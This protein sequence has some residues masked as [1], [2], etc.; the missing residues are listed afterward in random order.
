M[1]EAESPFVEKFPRVLSFRVTTE[2]Q[3]GH[4]RGLGSKRTDDVKSVSPWHRDVQHQHIQHVARDEFKSLETIGG[5]ALDTE[6]LV[7][8]QPVTKRGSDKRMVVR[9]PYLYRAASH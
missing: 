6:I 2:H 9:D 5:F 8:Q 7:F 4:S 3:D 1:Q